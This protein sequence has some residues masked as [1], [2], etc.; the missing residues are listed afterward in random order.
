MDIG[1]T[2][3]LGLPVVK[4]VEMGQ[5]IDHESVTTPCHKITGQIVLGHQWSQRT[6][7]LSIVQYPGIGLLGVPGLPA[8][9]HVAMGRQ[10]EHVHVTTPLQLMVG[11]IV[12][13]QEL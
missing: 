2:G 5:N 10:L 3:A 1:L 9:K 6:A 7:L 11:Q 4:H 13:V 8:V 12:L